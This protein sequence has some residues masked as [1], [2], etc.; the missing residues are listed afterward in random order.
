M[1]GDLK[2]MIK[3]GDKTMDEK[4]KAGE[5][6]PEM[7]K[8]S[9]VVRLADDALDDV[10]GGGNGLTVE[11]YE[12]DYCPFCQDF[13]V[14]VKC[15]ERIVYGK[16]DYPTSYCPSRGKY[17]FQASNGYYDWDGNCLLHQY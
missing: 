1:Y 2:C 7:E 5:R 15:R 8:M 16:Y 3:K 11:S 10:A 17:F 9:D 13:H 14:I 12:E 6:L 4:I